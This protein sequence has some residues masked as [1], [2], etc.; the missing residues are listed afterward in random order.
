MRYF[1]RLLFPMM[2]VLILAL[3]ISSCASS[4]SA[5][6]GTQSKPA[7]D[8]TLKVGQISNSIAFF[9]LYVAD[10]EGFFKAQKL[11]IGPRPLLGTGAKVAA[12][13]SAGSLE[14]GCGVIT[15]AFNL[16]KVD[17]TTKVIGS[18]VNSNYIDLI[19]S[20]KLEEETHVTSSSPLADRIN[21][22]R[23]KK[24]GITGP[25]SGTEALMTYLFKLAGLNVKKDA[26]LV[27]L[28]SDNTAVLG[29]LST[30]RVDALSFFAPIGQAVE[31]K[32]LGDI[33]ISPNRGDLPGLTGQLEGIFYTR[34]SVIDAKKPAIEAFIRAIAQ[35]KTYILNN[36]AKALVLLNNYLQLGQDVAQATWK[37]LQA[38]M[39]QGPEVSEQAYNTAVRF[40]EQAGLITTAPAY[41]SLIATST[42]AS[43]LSSK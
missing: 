42:I 37:A 31:A 27:N 14:V 10:K 29:A 12:A 19:A 11:D 17:P 24:I 39:G 16:A 35:A 22:L 38:I 8:M 3:D 18:L 4:S 41:N 1:V 6:T 34:Q 32:G 33:L 23:G 21:A 20:K 43:A 5:S 2:I 15:D 26:V 40:H 7:P 25:A 13:L 30:G 9:P 28:G 36:P